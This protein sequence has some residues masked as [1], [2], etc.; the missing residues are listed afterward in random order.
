MTSDMCFMGVERNANFRAH[1]CFLFLFNPELLKHLKK[2]RVAGYLK[3][4]KNNKTF[5][6][7]SCPSGYPQHVNDG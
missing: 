1:F 4:N 2:K 5:L 3:A 7:V 6:S